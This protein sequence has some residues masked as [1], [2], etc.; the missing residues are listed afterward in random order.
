[1][2]RYFIWR[3]RHDADEPDM[4]METYNVSE[5]ELGAVE[6]RVAVYNDYDEFGH[7]FDPSLPVY[8]YYISDRAPITPEEEV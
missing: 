5:D 1:M 6:N 7:R 4:W 3:R 2:P 8:E